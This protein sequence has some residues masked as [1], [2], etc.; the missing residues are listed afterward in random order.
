M[1][2]FIFINN[3]KEEF[4]FFIN[5]SREMALNIRDEKKELIACFILEHDELENLKTFLNN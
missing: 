1:E 3:A 4:K 5:E 2:E